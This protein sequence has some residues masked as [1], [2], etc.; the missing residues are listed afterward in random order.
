MEQL[1]NGKKKP[2]RKR[3]KRE[4]AL[5]EK[6]TAAAAAAADNGT[7][8]HCVETY[9]PAQLEFVDDGAEEVR[10]HSIVYMFEIQIM[11]RHQF[12]T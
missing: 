3:R 4:D 1:Q 9:P 10:M 5:P 7:S 12:V 6:P 8:Q 11:N 2:R